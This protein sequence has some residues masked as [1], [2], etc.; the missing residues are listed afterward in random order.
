MGH[1]PTQ[2][3][4][5]MSTPIWSAL[6]WDGNQPWDLQVLGPL[7]ITLCLSPAPPTPHTAPQK[8]NGTVGLGL[9]EEK[10]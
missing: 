8:G 10:L 4:A 6:P 1:R 9:S 5:D 7:F 3:K 2:L